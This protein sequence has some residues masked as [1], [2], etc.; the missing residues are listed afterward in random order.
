M[1]WDVD[2]GKAWATIMGCLQID[3]KARYESAGS[4]IAHHLI[5]LLVTKYGGEYDV[6]QIAD[7]KEATLLSCPPHERI[8]IFC[9]RLEHNWKKIG[10]C[11][12]NDQV[13]CLAELRLLLKKS[14]PRFAADLIYSKNN[15]MDYTTLRELCITN[16]SVTS[17]LQEIP[18]V[19]FDEVR[20][21][22]PDYFRGR[23]SVPVN[24]R[25]YDRRVDEY[26]DN[27]ANN[28]NYNSSRN[29]SQSD[30]RGRIGY[31]AR[32]RSPSPYPRDNKYDE[33]DD[34][35]R[36]NYRR[37]RDREYSRDRNRDGNRE[38]SRD[39]S[40][41]RS[42][43]RSR[44]DSHGH[45]RDKTGA[46]D[47]KR[48]RSQ[49]ADKK[50]NSK[51]QTNN[52]LRPCYAFQDG[53]CNRGSSC[54]FSHDT[55]AIRH[56]HSAEQ[57]KELKTCWTKKIQFQIDSGAKKSITNDKN[58]LDNYVKYSTPTFMYTI[59]GSEVPIIGEGHL[60]PNFPQVF[61]SPTADMGVIA[62]GDLQSAD[63]LTVFPP[64][65][66][67]GVFVLNPTTGEVLMKGDKNYELSSEALKSLLKLT[68]TGNNPSTNV[69]EV[70]IRRL[71]D[72]TTP[73]APHDLQYYDASEGFTFQGI[74]DQDAIRT[75]KSWT[76]TKETDIR[77]RVA[78]LTRQYGWCTKQQLI[79]YSRTIENFPVTEKQ[80]NKYY[81]IFPAA[82]QGKLTRSTFTYEPTL[83][84]K[85]M[86]IGSIVSTDF[87]PFKDGNN[88]VAGVQLFLDKLSNFLYYVFTATPGTSKV[89]GDCVAKATKF[90]AKY[91]H[92]LEVI[93]TDS[94]KG[95]S[96]SIYEKELDR[97][98]ITHQASAPHE[99]Q[100]NFVER[101]SRVMEEAVSTMQAAAPWVPGKLVTFCVILWACL[102]NLASG[103]T[104][105][106]S[107]MEQFTHKR[108]SANHT[109][110]PGTYGDTFAVH[111]PRN[112]K[113]E[114]LLD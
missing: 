60:G 109:G 108:P 15:N 88:G 21:T 6:D 85:P 95:Y 82:I 74:M 59:T 61:H 34:R 52:H 80:I 25:N 81:V 28:R 39:R 79:D 42:R 20:R 67:S 44:D 102:W 86:K 27:Y 54:S 7:F 36:E 97:L 16:D 47:D 83:H 45:Y 92:N 58:C 17:S 62:I 23:S 110:L 65:K 50:I 46:K 96:T 31:K 30:S 87:I 57:I 18:G 64:G 43:D 72:S 98:E 55:T 93:Q 49:S 84:T 19:T 41:D 12:V 71:T 89:L 70:E 99:Q 11:I 75:V 5:D 111:N 26:N 78:H 40:S 91:G 94:L 37:S 35:K 113:G 68:T 104:N 114:A 66:D 10:K 24:D 9:A 8:E 4:K 14:G 2:N 73:P 51:P 33:E 107:K 63:F 103:T 1:K 22:Q 90:Y 106:I 13:D 69:Q 53:H 56:V 3:L 38:R 101:A 77:Y 76:T 48:D 112:G 32:G 29:D 100:Q 105:G